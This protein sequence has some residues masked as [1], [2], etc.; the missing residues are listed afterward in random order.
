MLAEISTVAATYIV[1]V[2]PFTEHA[3]ITT[4]TIC[5][6]SLKNYTVTGP[7]RPS[8]LPIVPL[9]LLIN[10]VHCMSSYSSEL[11][12]FKDKQTTNIAITIHCQPFDAIMRSSFKPSVTGVVC[13]IYSDIACCVTISSALQEGLQ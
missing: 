13:Y 2:R 12:V 10:S 8:P 5:P 7:I 3:F 11:N 4:L 9:I 1:P 6:Q